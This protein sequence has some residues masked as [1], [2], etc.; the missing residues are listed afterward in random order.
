MVINI[1]ALYPNSAGSR[2]DASYYLN[3]HSAFADA[4]LRPHGLIALRATIGVESLDGQP[5]PFWAISEMHF[6]S[7]HAFDEAIATCGEA[8][9]ADLA[10]YTNT[11]PVLQISTIAD[12]A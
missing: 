3:R 9:F 2:F 12:R 1:S 5:P 7:R 8:L 10:N 4:L 6:V 11:T